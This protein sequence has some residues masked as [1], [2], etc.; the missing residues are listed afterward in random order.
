MKN[1]S[2]KNLTQLK[3]S[4]LF[5]KNIPNLN[6]SNFFIKS[7]E[8]DNNNLKE[9][10]NENENDSDKN[11]NPG[12]EFDDKINTNLSEHNNNKIFEENSFENAGMSIYS[13]IVIDRRYTKN[14]F[15]IYN[16]KRKKIVKRPF[17]TKVIPISF[18]N[19]DSK[20]NYDILNIIRK[21]AVRNKKLVFCHSKNSRNLNKYIEV[22]I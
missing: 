13:K 19:N 4:D 6:Y 8:N 9:K 22:K 1:F 20:K 2:E 17:L 12:P 7:L 15:N 18:F 5:I 11:Y 14:I 10:D 16:G 3:M 21:R